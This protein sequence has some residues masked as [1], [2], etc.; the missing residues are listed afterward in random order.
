MELYLNAFDFIKG[1]LKGAQSKLHAF[2]ASTFVLYV[3]IERQAW[4]IVAT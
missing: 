3:Y 1:R 4:D 2:N